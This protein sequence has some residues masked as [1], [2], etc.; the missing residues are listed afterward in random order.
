MKYPAAKIDYAMWLSQAIVTLSIATYL[1][2]RVSQQKV[3]KGLIRQLLLLLIA[4]SICSIVFYCTVAWAKDS[5]FNSLL[6][7]ITGGGDISLK[8]SALS[9]FAFK[10]LD[11]S[12]ERPYFKELPNGKNSLQLANV[13]Q[14]RRILKVTKFLKVIMLSLFVA[15]WALVTTS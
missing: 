10:Y 2:R 7:S 9:L 3:S 12:L 15:N 8:G 5:T 6:I 11:A 1:Y 4:E 14:T 13:D